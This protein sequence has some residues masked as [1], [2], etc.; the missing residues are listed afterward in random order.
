MNRFQSLTYYVKAAA[1]LR[2][3]LI[4]QKVAEVLQAK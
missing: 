3:E 4:E 1:D 2:R